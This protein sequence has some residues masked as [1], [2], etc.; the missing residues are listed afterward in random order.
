MR[1]LISGLPDP[2]WVEAVNTAVYLH[3]R[4]PSK[5]AWKA[6]SELY[7]RKPGLK[8]LNTFVS[9]AYAHFLKEKGQNL[10]PRGAMGILV[11]M[12]KVEKADFFVKV[13]NVVHI[14]DISSF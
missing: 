12:L 1:N 8:H 13:C 5:V 6:L 7:E 14:D 11:D 3:N 2:C 10:D 4:I 9:K